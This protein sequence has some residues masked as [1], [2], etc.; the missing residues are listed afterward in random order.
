[1]N[2]ERPPRMPDSQSLGELRG[3]AYPNA[4]FALRAAAVLAFTGFVNGTKSK[5]QSRGVFTIGWVC[6]RFG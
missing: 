4:T 1:M 5:L 2:R 6:C 3:E